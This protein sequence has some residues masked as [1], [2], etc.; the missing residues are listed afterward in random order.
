[1][2]GACVNNDTLSP[3]QQQQQKK[4]KK[5]VAR[6]EDQLF[7]WDVLPIPPP[8]ERTRPKVQGSE[9]DQLEQ[10]NS[11]TN[12]PEQL[13][14]LNWF[15]GSPS[16]QTPPRH[17]TLKAAHRKPTTKIPA[18]EFELARPVYPGDIESTALG[19]FRSSSG[20]FGIGTSM[21]DEIPIIP[22]V[23]TLEVRTGNIVNYNR[24]K[25]KPDQ[26]PTVEI[27][28]CVTATVKKYLDTSDKTQLQYLK[29][30][31]C[32][33][34]DVQQTLPPE[35]R[36]DLKVIVKVFI[37]A[38]NQ[39]PEVITEIIGKATE[40]LGI[41]FVETVILSISMFETEEE[42]TVDLIKPYWQVLENLVTQELILSIGVADLDKKKLDELYNW[43]RIKPSIDQVNLASC[44]VMPKDLTEYAKLVDIQ[45]QTH[46]DPPELFPSSQL[47]EA[48]RQCGTEQDA[49]GW[50]ALWV[51]RYSV[52]VKCRG[53]IKSKGY[54][55]RATR[56]P[57]RRM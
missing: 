37:C 14:G 50:T 30:I 2:K 16:A 18:H 36:G 22:K 35:E 32:V 20:R 8:K 24:L 1:M 44:C 57:H 53:I 51:A 47:Q 6:P 43:A 55:V 11:Q 34:R 46:S 48:M 28:E 56:D 45:L 33:D 13:S 49:Y 40:E 5:K 31:Q 23:S 9:T 15:A 3:Q 4:N 54:I 42:I 29:E 25:R 12:I 39:P 38:P 21:A 26:T 10:S 27:F 7:G 19:G 17:I 41:S 52:L